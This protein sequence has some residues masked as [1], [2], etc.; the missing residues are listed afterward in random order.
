[1]KQVAWCV[2]RV[3]CFGYAQVGTDG[4]P[5][6]GKELPDGGDGLLDHSRGAGW[7]GPR[8]GRTPSDGERLRLDPA[9]TGAG[10]ADVLDEGGVDQAAGG[11]DVSCCRRHT[12]FP[13]CPN[14]Y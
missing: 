1:V 9:L 10:P 11:R 5:A 2:L 12:S 7:V 14:M 4:V 8:R 6:F 3:A 13:T